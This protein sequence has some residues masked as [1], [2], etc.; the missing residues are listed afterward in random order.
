MQSVVLDWLTFLV[1]IPEL[2]AVGCRSQVPLSVDNQLDLGLCLLPLLHP[3][4]GHG[5]T[6]MTRFLVGSSLLLANLQVAPR[7][8]LDSDVRIPQLQDEHEGH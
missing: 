6:W 7:L 5:G 4:P 1:V 2:V 8:Q 3:L